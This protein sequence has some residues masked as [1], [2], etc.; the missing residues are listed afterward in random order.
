MSA[1]VELPD[2]ESMEPQ[3]QGR[4]EGLYAMQKQWR[5]LFLFDIN[6]EVQVKWSIV[7][8]ISLLN[9]DK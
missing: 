8:N 6:T 3:E 7:S 2:H 4:C 1:P 9:I 5:E